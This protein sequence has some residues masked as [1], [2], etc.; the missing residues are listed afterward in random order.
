[1]KNLIIKSLA[2]VGIFAAACT[3]LEVKPKHI[4]APDLILSTPESYRSYI[5]KLYAG[6]AI[7]GQEGPA[8]K[9]DVGGIDEGFSSYL[10]GYWKAQELSTDEAVI[11]WGDDGIRDF[12]FQNWTSQNQF[13]AGIYYRVFYQISLANEFL[14]QTTEDKLTE[15]GLKEDLKAEVA[16]YRTEARFLRALS[17]W[18]GMDL[19][20]NIPF[21]TEADPIG[22]FKPTQADRNKVFAFIESELLA[23]ES[24][25]AEARTNEYGR[26][27]QGA[28]W[29]LLAKL[30]LN[31][32]VYTGTAKYTE[33][34]TYCKKIIAAGYS[35]QTNYQELFLTDNNTSD[36]VIF[37]VNFDGM[38]TRTWG[39][40]TFLI[41]ASVGGSMDPAEYGIDGGWGGTR[42][43]SALVDLFPDETGTA[44]KRSIFYTA[45]QSKTISDVGTF[46]QGYAV[47]KFR[48]VSSTGVVGSHLTHP[49]TDFPM[50]RLA[51]VYLM[52]AESVV[53][54]GSGGST[55]EAV[56]Y[57]NELRE[58]AYGDTSGNIDVTDLTLDFMLDERGRELYWEAHRRTDLI[59]F[60]VFT[61]NPTNNLKAIWP[62]KG[63]TATGKATESFRDLYPIPSSELIANTNLDQNDGY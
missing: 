38:H 57:I 48:N 30:Y 35:L 25:I 7:T 2:A 54:G 43:T 15:R 23:I 51:D 47:P 58:R 61:A 46:S 62:W 17:Y 3:D 45:G 59:R 4:A 55:G 33:C 29:T 1:M 39:G 60:K 19:F 34:I 27:D 5:A 44:D 21:I 28:V 18:H 56:A 52:F 11:A 24:E 41:H 49:D 8:G 37:A 36:E 20:G 9:G 40:M 16:Q 26:A 22:A 6:L 12:H 10:R 13:I 31:A 42:T 53:R 50:F 63:N 32:E 14:R